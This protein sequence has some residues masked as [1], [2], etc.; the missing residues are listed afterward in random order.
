MLPSERND[1]Y[2]YYLE[3][4]GASTSVEDLKREGFVPALKDLLEKGQDVNSK[5]EK[6]NTLLH[7]VVSNETVRTLAEEG[8]KTG[9]YTHVIDVPFM[10]A[11][12]QKKLNPFVMD[13]NG[14]TPS[15]L[16]AYYG[17]TKDHGMLLSLESA[18]NHR[19]NMIGLYALSQM[20]CSSEFV[21]DTGHRVWMSN[22]QN[23]EFV[24]ACNMVK[25]LRRVADGKA[26]ELE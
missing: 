3:Q 22:T 13:E 23:E 9:D 16:A 12:Y 19:R 7:Y 1:Y 14:F 20:M 18:V 26:K 5:D 8:R 6:G 15:C 2:K 4:L 17:N 24:A 11:S 10:I 25:N 21:T